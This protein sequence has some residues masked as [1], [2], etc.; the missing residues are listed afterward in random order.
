MNVLCKRNN[1][2]GE[3][4]KTVCRATWRER[5]GDFITDTIAMCRLMMQDASFSLQENNVLA[6]IAGYVVRK[7]KYKVCCYCKESRLSILE[8]ADECIHG[9]RLKANMV[10]LLAERVDLSILKC[11]VC[12]MELHLTVN[13]RLHHTARIH[14]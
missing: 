10:A 11:D 12:Y 13:T 1:E 7:V 9:E 4:T 3:N 14:Y 6:Y 8:V 2:G 5:W